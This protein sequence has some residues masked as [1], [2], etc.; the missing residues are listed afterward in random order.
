MYFNSYQI[1][2]FRE[3]YSKVD[4]KYQALVEQYTAL[5]LNNQEA[6]EYAYHGFTRRIGILKRC[7]DNIYTICPP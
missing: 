4:S 3:E 2:Q 7:I 1:N 5:K 6:Y